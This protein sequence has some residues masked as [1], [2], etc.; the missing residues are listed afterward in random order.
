MQQ[1]DQVAEFRSMQQGDEVAERGLTRRRGSWEWKNQM[2]GKEGVWSTFSIV[3]QSKSGSS[4]GC[5]FQ[6]NT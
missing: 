1:R 6:K 4:S 3:G 5:Q 2:M